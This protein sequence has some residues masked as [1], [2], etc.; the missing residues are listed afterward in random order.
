[1]KKIVYTLVSLFILV[2]MFAVI[3]EF[4]KDV[5][6]QELFRKWVASTWEQE[7]N[8]FSVTVDK[9]M[10]HQNMGADSNSYDFRLGIVSKNEEKHFSK[11]H[12]KQFERFFEYQVSDGEIKQLQIRGIYFFKDSKR[13]LL[14]TRDKAVKNFLLDLNREDTLR[15]WLINKLDSSRIEINV[16]NSTI[17]SWLDLVDYKLT[18]EERT[19]AREKRKRQ[20]RK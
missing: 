6:G 17:I 13:L 15:L 5:K 16:P 12:E 8:R 2:A 14:F 18:K 11:A 19:K 3:P 7:E 9:K 4:S 20:Q 1:M 10:R